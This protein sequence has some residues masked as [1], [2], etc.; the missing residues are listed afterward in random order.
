MLSNFMTP[1]IQKDRESGLF[2]LSNVGPYPE[3]VSLIIHFSILEKL[4]LGE[5]TIFLK[6]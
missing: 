4:H 2:L 6:S 3:L 5:N 1:L